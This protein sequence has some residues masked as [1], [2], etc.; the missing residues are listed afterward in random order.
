MKIYPLFFFSIFSFIFS[1]SLSLQRSMSIILRVDVR[2]KELITQFDLLKTMNPAFAAIQPIQI[3]TLPLGDIIISE[4]HPQTGELYD[5][6]IIERKKIS[7]LYASIKDGRYEEQSFR[8]SGLPTIHNHNV[9]YLIEGRLHA[10]QDHSTFFSSLFSL[11]YYK[12]FSIL[13]TFNIEETAFYLFNLAKRLEKNNREKKYPLRGYYGTFL[14]ASIPTASDILNNSTSQ[15]LSV[16]DPTVVTATV[17]LE[18]YSTVTKKVKK[19]NITPENIGEI[20][21]STVPGISSITA[22][23]IMEH[24]KT[25]DRL[26]QTLKEIRDDKDLP[27]ITYI[28]KTNQKQK[29]INKNVIQNIRKFLL[30]SDNI[31]TKENPENPNT[32]NLENPENNE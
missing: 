27:E 21:L 9:V 8:L 2:E 29:K 23:A 32:E 11:N 17:P 24:Y 13:R 19:D 6:L 28:C 14:P 15:P 18:S 25:M 31:T 26:L 22:I 10:S 20:M 16:I 1:D 12:G 5:H 7:D 3:E 30:T 4:R